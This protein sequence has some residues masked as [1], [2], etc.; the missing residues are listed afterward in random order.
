VDGRTQTEG[1]KQEAD[2]EPLNDVGDVLLLSRALFRPRNEIVAVKP[3][4]VDWQ[5]N[6]VPFNMQQGLSEKWRASS[7]ALR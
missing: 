7:F 4:K 3:A 5:E 1:R 2:K 6:S